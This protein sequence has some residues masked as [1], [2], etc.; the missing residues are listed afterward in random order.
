MRHISEEQISAWVDRQLDP[1]TMALVDTHLDTCGNC[2]A[3]AEEMSAITRAY[4]SSASLELPPHLWTRVAA[5]MADAGGHRG[6]NQGGWLPALLTRPAWLPVPVVL[7]ALMI[8][9]AGTVVFVEHRSTSR[10]ERLALAQIETTR[11]TMASLD[12]EKY[13]PFRLPAPVDA[14]M[15]PFARS[16][17]DP[18]INPFSAA[19]QNRQQERQP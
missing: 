19:Q 5:R 6:W 16:S 8:S 4:R 14:K 13:N 17:V 15:N 18:L 12:T 2:R 3:L 11:V 10:L 9:I 1:A 7:I